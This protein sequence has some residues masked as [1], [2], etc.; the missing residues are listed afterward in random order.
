MTVSGS[1]YPLRSAGR[2]IYGGDG[3][4]WPTATVNGNN[5]RKGI[6]KK[7]GDGLATA[8]RMWKTP[9]ASDGEGGIMEMRP[10]VN[11]HYKLRD[12]VQE[13]NRVFWP[14]PSATDYKGSGTDAATLRDRLDYAAER[15][16]TKNKLFPTPRENCSTGKCEHGEGGKDLQ[17]AVGGKLNPRWVEWL[18]GVPI[19]WTA[20]KPLATGTYRK[21]L[22]AFSGGI[23][24]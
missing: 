9:N 22:N 18:M 23:R 13:I 8:V 20:L 24:E 14:T 4:L 16:K 2:R 21:W 7:A 6:T 11:G 17:T 10:G 12:Q 3:G 1:A 19:G 15:G 5:N